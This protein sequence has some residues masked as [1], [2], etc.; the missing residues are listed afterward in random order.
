MVRNETTI[1]VKKNSNGIR[2]L[3]LCCVVCPNAVSVGHDLMKKKAGS[4]FRS[5][6]VLNTGNKSLH[7]QV[8][9]RYLDD[10]AEDENKNEN[11]FMV[12]PRRGLLALLCHGA[13]VCIRHR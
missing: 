4:L 8:E 3:A 6:S 5:L 7:L 9:I 11:L 13:M 1:V 12:T 2:W 10:C